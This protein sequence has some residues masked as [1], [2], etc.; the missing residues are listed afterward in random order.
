MCCYKSEEI[1]VADSVEEEEKKKNS[2]VD[3]LFLKLVGRGKGR[4]EGARLEVN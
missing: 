3:L 1:C 4:K 2:S